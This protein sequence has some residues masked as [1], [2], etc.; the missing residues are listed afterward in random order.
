MVLIITIHLGHLNLLFL[1]APVF[2]IVETHLPSYK[3]SLQSKAFIST[4][5]R[6]HSMEGQLSLWSMLCHVLMCQIQFHQRQ[7]S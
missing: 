1:E 5:G 2:D 3:D 4:S 6:N 7:T